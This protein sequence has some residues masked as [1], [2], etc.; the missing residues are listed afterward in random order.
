MA[1]NLS[2]MGAVQGCLVLMSFGTES[3]PMKLIEELLCI[4]APSKFNSLIEELLNDERLHNSPCRNGG[5]FY[6]NKHKFNLGQVIQWT[7]QYEEI[8]FD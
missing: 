1:Q 3:M 4:S 2:H 6:R 8:E 5:L 7:E